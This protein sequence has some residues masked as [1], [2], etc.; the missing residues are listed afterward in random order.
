MLYALMQ[1]W[2]S[3]F[4]AQGSLMTGAGPSKANRRRLL[5]LR[6]IFMTESKLH[7]ESKH[8]AKMK[9][10]SLDRIRLNVTLLWRSKGGR[11]NTRKRS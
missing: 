11:E 7:V 2:Q 1:E 5:E 9:T 6:S 10:E 3:G 4:L 8:L